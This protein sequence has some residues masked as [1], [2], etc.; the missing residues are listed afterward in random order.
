MK[1]AVTNRLPVTATLGRVKKAP[2]D[3]FGR[4][5]LEKASVAENKNRLGFEE[6]RVVKK[7]C[8]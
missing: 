5:L 8:S 1:H 4:M 6:H 7:C 3:V 2:N